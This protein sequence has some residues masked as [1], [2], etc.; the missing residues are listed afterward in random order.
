M[1]IA[2]TLALYTSPTWFDDIFGTPESNIQK[3]DFVRSAPNNG[4]SGTLTVGSRTFS[5]GVFH[6]IPFHRYP[7][8]RGLKASHDRGLKGK[9]T[10]RIEI[11]TD[12]LKLVALPIANG[13]FIQVASQLNALESPGPYV[14]DITNYLWDNTQG[15]RASMPVAAASLY[16]K[17]Y[18]PTYNALR[19]T[20]LGPFVDHGFLRLTEDICRP[21]AEG[22]KDALKDL[23]NMTI[24]MTTNLT[25][26]LVAQTLDRPKWATYQ[27][28]QFY[29]ASAPTNTKIPGADAVVYELLKRQYF[30]IGYMAARWGR[31]TGGP[32][33]VHLTLV[34]CGAFG[35]NP[36]IVPRVIK[37]LLEEVADSAI[38]FVLHVFREH[39]VTLELRDLEQ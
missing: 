34:G 28:V 30:A 35:N 27:I 14:V 1:N 18:H 4:I 37:E 19:E 16:R 33:T 6:T 2:M 29:T 5:T 32:I 7:A 39:E 25:P 12:V 20:K 13:T 3:S 26:D 11:G 10:L 17:L 22:N 31:A 15:P 9:P 36:S 24:P 8:Y 21:F 38:N 23:D